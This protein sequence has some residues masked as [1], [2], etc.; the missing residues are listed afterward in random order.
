MQTLFTIHATNDD[1]LQ[2]V[3]AEMRRLG[4]PTIRVVDCGDYLMALEGTHRIAAAAVLQMPLNLV[5][6]EQGDLVEAD[7]LDWQ[8]LQH[9]ESYSAGELACEAFSPSCGIY[10]LHDDG[11]V[12]AG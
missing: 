7:S 4:P 11:T 6:L 12:E 3:I 1:K 5:S 9:G 2:E 8:D 10:R